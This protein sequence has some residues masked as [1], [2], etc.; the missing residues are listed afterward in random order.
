MSIGIGM[1]GPSRST[2]VWARFSVGAEVLSG[3][4]TEGFGVLPDIFE[5]LIGYVVL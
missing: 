1:R 2:M 4:S 3:M 5:R